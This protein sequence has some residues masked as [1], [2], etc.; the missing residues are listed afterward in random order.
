M[1]K[2]EKRGLE[3]LAHDVQE[4]LMEAKR[5]KKVTF[6]DSSMDKDVSNP[7]K[8]LHSKLKSAAEQIQGLVLERD[9]LQNLGNKLRSEVVGLKEQLNAKKTMERIGDLGKEKKGRDGNDFNCLEDLHYR[10]AMDELRDRPV[11]MQK[12]VQVELASSSESSLLNVEGESG[13][14]G[15][16]FVDQIPVQDL[17][18]DQL[19]ATDIKSGK[20]STPTNQIGT[21]RQNVRSKSPV[22]V[23][24]SS[25]LSS[26]QDLWKILD[27]AE[28]LASQTPRSGRPFGKMPKPIPSTDQETRMG[29][30]S[31]ASVAEIEG[32]HM[33]LQR[34]EQAREPKLSK[35]AQG[36]FIPAKKPQRIRNYNEK[37]D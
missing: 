3:N 23:Y 2:A 34:K 10:L 9:R 20:S 37:Q 24:S 18:V 6:L 12:D 16:D 7:D 33:V 19:V 30:Q 17:E 35:L 15:A 26:L 28:S 27:E 11:S 14:I 31:R 32:Q 25:E 1:L 22:I 29:Q 21:D 13:N 4:Q 36:K 8:R 5:Q